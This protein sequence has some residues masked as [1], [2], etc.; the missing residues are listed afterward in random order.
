M[1]MTVVKNMKK[2]VFAIFKLVLSG[3]NGVT[4]EFV[5]E[6]AVVVELLV[7]DHVAMDIEETLVALEIM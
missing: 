6:H 2:S 1:Q 4:G 7:S 3:E 5:R